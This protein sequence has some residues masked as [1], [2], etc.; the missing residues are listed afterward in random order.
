MLGYAIAYIQISHH[1][2]QI[3]LTASFDLLFAWL[4][5]LPT[6]TTFSVID[7]YLQR[8]HC[9]SAITSFI[10]MSLHA[11]FEVVALVTSFRN[12]VAFDK[13]LLF[14]V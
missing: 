11:N 6:T 9:V 8:Y 1:L 14:H 4:R 5:A 7:R 10:I 2:P 12:F 3:A 13:K